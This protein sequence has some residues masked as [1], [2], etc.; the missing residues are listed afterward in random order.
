MLP[1]RSR[2]PVHTITITITNTIRY[3]IKIY[4]NIGHLTVFPSGR[5]VLQ[6]TLLCSL[7]TQLNS[8]HWLNQLSS[9]APG[10]GGSPRVPS[11]SCQHISSASC[12]PWLPLVVAAPVGTHPFPLVPRSPPA[13][14]LIQCL[15][16]S[17]LQLVQLQLSC[18]NPSPTLAA[19]HLLQLLLV[20]ILPPSSSI[21]S[22]SCT[23]PVPPVS[24]CCSSLSCS[25][26]GNPS[27][28]M[29]PHYLLLLCVFILL[30]CV[31]R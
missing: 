16:L 21:P 27:S 24:P 9:V 1:S 22:Y 7:N 15:L 2:I 14:A 4:Q 13:P 31:I 30:L 25:S 17:W 29:V 8:Q 10:G 23:D 12:L 11:Q 3:G 26:R 6:L 19:T 20:P 5:A 18:G 28:P